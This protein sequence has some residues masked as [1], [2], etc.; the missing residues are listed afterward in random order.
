MQRIIREENLV[1]NVRKQGILLEEL[2]HKHLD[3]HPYVGNIR[4]KGLFWGVGEI[5]RSKFAAA[6]HRTGQIEFVADKKTKEPFPPSAGV[7]NAVHI[8]GLNDLGIS[9]YPGTGTKNGVDGD[10][11]LLSPAYT[12]TSEEIEEI[13]QKVKET[14]FQTFEELEKTQDTV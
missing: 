12:S 7:A 13:A 3:D 14:V 4:G 5:P 2:L 10:H 8:K 9:L 1:E 6:A 11:V